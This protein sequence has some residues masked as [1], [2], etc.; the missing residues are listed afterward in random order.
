[1][2]NVYDIAKTGVDY[3]SVGAITHSAKAI[4]FSLNVEMEKKR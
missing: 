4:D 2:E 3:I 1:L